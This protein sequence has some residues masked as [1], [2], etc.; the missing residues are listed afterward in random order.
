M[1]QSRGNLS[2]R[3]HRSIPFHGMGHAAQWM[4][5]RDYQKAFPKKRRMMTQWFA[6]VRDLMKSGKGM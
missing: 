1:Q 3:K 5:M 4:W 2:H 6:S